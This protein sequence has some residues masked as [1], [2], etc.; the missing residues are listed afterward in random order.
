MDLGPNCELQYLDG[1]GKKKKTVPFDH[2]Q[3]YTF[4]EGI[5]KELHVKG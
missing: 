4:D 2:A 3:L 5:T 1:T